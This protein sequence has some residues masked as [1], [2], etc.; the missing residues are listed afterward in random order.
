MH[1]PNGSEKGHKP[2]QW[3]R[4][5]RTEG[6]T[7]NTVTSTHRFLICMTKTETE[8]N[9]AKAQHYLIFMF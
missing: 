5:I 2:W 1:N 7:I 4:G 6:V 8:R 3:Q 9:G